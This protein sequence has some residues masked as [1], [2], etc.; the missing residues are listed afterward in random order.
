MD[1]HELEASLVYKASSRMVRVTQRSP[2]LKKQS[3]TGRAYYT[4]LAGFRVVL[5]PR[6][7][8]S[9]NPPGFLSYI[10]FKDYFI[11]MGV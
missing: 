11:C 1:L 4:V 2:I 8:L 6:L 5:W 9:S 7:I 3:K 10:F